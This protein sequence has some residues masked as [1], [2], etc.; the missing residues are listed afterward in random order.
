MYGDNELPE[1]PDVWTFPSLKLEEILH[2]GDHSGDGVVDLSMY[3]HS[4]PRV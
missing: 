2:G 4:K 3:T 1:F